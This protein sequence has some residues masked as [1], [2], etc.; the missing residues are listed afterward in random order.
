MFRRP[1]TCE[2]CAE[3]GLGTRVEREYTGGVRRA[4]ANNPEDEVFVMVLQKRNSVSMLFELTESRK[5]MMIF[6]LLC[7]LVML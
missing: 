3:I 1:R 5:R 2:N 6:T 7:F 4:P